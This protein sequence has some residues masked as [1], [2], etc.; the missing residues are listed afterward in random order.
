MLRLHAITESGV[1]P[2]SPL[3]CTAGRR[4][5]MK[6]ANALLCLLSS[7]GTLSPNFTATFRLYRTEREPPLASTV[8][9]TRV[10]PL[11]RQGGEERR[12]QGKERMLLETVVAAR[13]HRS[14]RLPLSRL[15]I[16]HCCSPMTP[17]RCST[18]ATVDRHYVVRS[19]VAAE[20]EDHHCRHRGRRL[21]W[22]YCREPQSELTAECCF[23]AEGGRGINSSKSTL[24]RPGVETAASSCG[25]ETPASIAILSTRALIPGCPTATSVSNSYFSCCCGGDGVGVNPKSSCE[26]VGVEG[27]SMAL[28]TLS[29]LDMP[30]NV[31]LITL[32]GALRFPMSAITL[33]NSATVEAT[34]C[35]IP[36]TLSTL[37]GDTFTVGSA[38]T[39]A[40]TF[41]PKVAAATTAGFAILGTTVPFPNAPYLF[42]SLILFFAFTHY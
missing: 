32:T 1:P 5:G 16:D 13:C 36:V 37:D 30:E 41:C 40:S 26:A 3:P 9:L 17:P 4:T 33:P 24:T 8:A 29:V 39:G 14:P 18:D 20:M 27:A 21:R 7:T 31:F 11:C 38:P 34:F 10:V 12:K 2:T 42:S 15:R 19:C 25:L 23:T 35:K 28:A 6:P 22:V